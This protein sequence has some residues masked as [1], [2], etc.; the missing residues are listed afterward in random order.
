MDTRE[1]ARAIKK[2]LAEF[3]RRGLKHISSKLPVG[4]YM[5]LDNARLVI[6]RKQNLLELCVNVCQQHKRFKAELMRANNYGIKLIILCEHDANIKSLDDVKH[7]VNP[8]LVK[9]PMAVSG[10]RLYKLLTAMSKKY[11]TEILFC[12]KKETGAKIIELLMPE[13]ARGDTR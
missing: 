12:S 2:I 8:R 9:S 5:S 11:N 3:D 4:D 7:W 6:D 13:L 10:E 1:K